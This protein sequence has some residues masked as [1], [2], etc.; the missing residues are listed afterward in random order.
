MHWGMTYGPGLLGAVVSSGWLST[1]IVVIQVIIGFSLIIFVHELGHFLAAK[2]V[3]IRVDRFAVGFGHRLFGWRKGEGFTLGNRPNYTPDEVRQRSWGETDYC[4][5]LLPIGGYVK[6]LGQDDI[7]VNE[8]TG[9]VKL[10]DDPRAFTNKPVGQRMF[11][12]SAGVLANLLFAIVAF[13]CVFMLGKKEIAPQI[14]LVDPVSPAAAAGLRPGDIIREANGSRV[15]SFRDIIVAQILATD[16]KVRF[17]VERDGKRLPDE[18]VMQL[19]EADAADPLASGLTA[20]G[21]NELQ[22]DDSVTES[23]RAAGRP[24]AQPGDVVTHVAGQPVTGAVDIST[25]ITQQVARTGHP[26]VELAL[27]RADSQDARTSTT[28]MCYTTATML[29][30]ATRVSGARDVVTD[31]QHIL[32]FLPRQKVSAVESGKPA[33]GGGLKPGDVIA[34]WDTVLNPTYGE[35]VASIRSHPKQEISVVVDRGGQSVNL[36]ITPQRPFYLFRAPPPRIGVLFGAGT[37]ECPVVADVAAGTRAAR[38]N[39]PRGA[40][41]LSIDGTPVANWFEVAHVLTAAAGQSVLIRYR[42][43]TLEGEAALD[44]PPSLV[45]ELNLPPTTM[46]VSIAGENRARLDDGTTV[47]LPN[48]LAAKLLLERHAGR[49][50]RVVWQPVPGDPQLREADFT[51]RA[52]LSNADPWQLRIVYAHELRFAPKETI[53]RTDNPLAAA[54]LGLRHTGLVLGEVYQ[55]IKTISRNL[56]AQRTDTVQHVSGPVGIVIATVDRAKRGF[57]ELL[58]FLAFLSVN[59]AV[60]NFLPFPVVDGGLMVFLLIEK[61]KGKPLSL[62]T[63]MVATLVGLAT[64]VLVFLLVTIQDISKIFS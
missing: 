23:A 37:G 52:D 16:R 36:S 32:G 26:L 44:V 56:A 34:Q 40:Q 46:M 50:V 25:A 29:I 48:P 15:A 22:S 33:Q 49:S 21:T 20:F 41:L 61:I 53:T 51:V 45:N 12:V 39:L 1:T 62:K 38:L 2:W 6:M 3:G 57:P 14:G 59:L 55:T 64:I 7:Q 60:I 5:K 28:Q 30:A 13:M 4:F 35:I 17:V 11:V 24:T 19:S 27:R 9:D 43:G 47:R 31:S 8:Q 18:L 42:A 63:Q 58:F 54:H 10:S